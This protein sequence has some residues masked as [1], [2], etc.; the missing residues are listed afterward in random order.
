M[1]I[2]IG[3]L[4]PCYR[5]SWYNF[6]NQ[7]TTPTLTHT[8]TTNI[9]I[10]PHLLSSFS[11]LYVVH[12]H[13]MQFEHISLL[14]CCF[15]FSSKE[16]TYTEQNGLELP[17]YTLCQLIV[18]NKILIL[19]CSSPCQSSALLSFIPLSQSQFIFQHAF[20]PSY[21][22]VRSH[23]VFSRNSQAIPRINALYVSVNKQ[24]CILVRA[25]VCVQSMIFFLFPLGISY[26]FWKNR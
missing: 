5:W 6:N 19:L 9:T 11:A 10:Y 26:S 21:S 25:C 14:C 2:L 18:C 23:K 16:T 24:V 1:K 13:F 8:S 12:F 4:R 17:V 7:V 22:F 3:C 15:T 20:A